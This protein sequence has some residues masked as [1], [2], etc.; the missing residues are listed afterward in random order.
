MWLA[1]LKSLSR[2]LKGPPQVWKLTDLLVSGG[3]GVRGLARLGTLEVAAEVVGVMRNADAP[4]A[5]NVA[6]GYARPDALHKPAVAQ[7]LWGHPPRGRCRCTDNPAQQAD[8]APNQPGAAHRG[9][10]D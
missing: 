10:S 2:G 4:R 5:E 6:A 8:E 1:V 7:C 9:P 3:L